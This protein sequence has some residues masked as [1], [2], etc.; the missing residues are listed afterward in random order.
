[1]DLKRLSGGHVGNPFR[2]HVYR[3]FAFVPG[4]DS[5]FRA[6]SE[7]PRGWERMRSSRWPGR[8]PA[9][10]A[11]VR[12]DLGGRY[13]RVPCGPVDGPHTV[14]RP[15][16]SPEDMGRRAG[17]LGRK[18]ARRLGFRALVLEDSQRENGYPDCRLDRR[19]GPSRETW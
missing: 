3:P 15:H 8:V 6:F 14:L 9:H 10:P 11:L 19:G 7:A 4:A 18:P 17:G 1:M 16:L 5:L 13:L 12:G 2:D